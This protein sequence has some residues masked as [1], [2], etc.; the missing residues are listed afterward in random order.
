MFEADCKVGSLSWKQKPYETR[1]NRGK[2]RDTDCEFCV[3]LVHIMAW[4]ILLVLSLGFWSLLLMEQAFQRQ[5]FSRMV[6]G[7][8]VAVAAGGVLGVYFLMRDCIQYLSQDINLQS[9][10][11][12]MADSIADLNE[13]LDPSLWIQ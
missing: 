6:G 10:G 13:F 3:T 5:E 8:L 7:T 1:Q 12:S 2:E 4:I 11:V 9:S